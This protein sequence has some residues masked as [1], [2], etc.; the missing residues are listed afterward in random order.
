MKNNFCK[1]LIF[2]LLILITGCAVDGVVTER[3][4][5]WYMSAE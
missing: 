3:P 1:I 2:S 5:I 4:L